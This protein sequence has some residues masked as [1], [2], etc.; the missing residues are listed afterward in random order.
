LL[1]ESERSR[2][3]ALKGV[4]DPESS[5]AFYKADF[6]SLTQKSKLRFHILYSFG[7][8]SMRN[9]FISSDYTLKEMERLAAL[10]NLEESIRYEPEFYASHIRLGIMY[11]DLKLKLEAKKY[12]EMART[13]FSKKGLLT[14]QE[15][16]NSVL[17]DIS[18]CYANSVPINEHIASDISKNMLKCKTIGK[19]DVECVKRDAEIVEKIATGWPF[20]VHIKTYIEN[21][22][23]LLTR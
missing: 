9:Y 17:C 10:R 1:I 11:L 12:F 22:S 23:I 19:A 8:S 2:G 5:L 4:N 14:N 20:S 21:C 18:F 3:A 13:T 15:F 16:L 6:L 7:Y